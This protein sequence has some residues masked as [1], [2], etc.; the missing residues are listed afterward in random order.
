MTI[1]RAEGAAEQASGGTAHAVAAAAGELLV[2]SD[3]LLVNSS[4]S[5]IEA[6]MW[7]LASLPLI[8]DTGSSAAAPKYS[9][10]IH[11]IV[12]ACA[13]RAHPGIAEGALWAL[14]KYA[15]DLKSQSFNSPPS[16]ASQMVITALGNHRSHAGVTEAGCCVL[17]TLSALSGSFQRGSALA[18]SV[19]VNALTDHGVGSVRIAAAAC[20][21]LGNHTLSDEGALAAVRSDAVPIILRVFSGHLNESGDQRL[22]EGA[23]RVLRN[24]FGP[25]VGSADMSALT[26]EIR[27]EA[28]RTLAECVTLFKSKPSIIEEAVWALVNLL[29][30]RDS[31]TVLLKAAAVE[32][33]LFQYLADVLQLAS[34]TANGTAACLTGIWCLATTDDHRV[35]A[36]R[37][38]VIPAILRNLS[39]YPTSSLIGETGCQALWA[40]CC[41]N[42]ANK[43][44]ATLGGAQDVLQAVKTRQGGT[45]AAEIARKLIVALS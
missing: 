25:V 34:T 17:S 2:R 23:C 6:G 43:Q 31:A 29:R 4:V 21:A 26:P 3:I 13:T 10:A 36:A 22:I 35:A 37:V 38:K 14:Y 1:A 39:A 44:I 12:A 32:A 18:V 19:L 7:A 20:H 16:L 5:L 41:A 15:S 28:I 8:P 11:L 30:G 40:V 33:R 9:K 45:V 24:V 42:S 27:K